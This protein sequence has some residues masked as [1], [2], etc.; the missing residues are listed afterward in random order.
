MVQALA[1]H[2]RDAQIIE[3]WDSMR[4][5]NWILWVSDGAAL[6]RVFVRCLPAGVICVLVSIAA[7]R[8][9][10]PTLAA[11]VGGIGAIA[12]ICTAL[13]VAVAFLEAV[14]VVDFVVSRLRSR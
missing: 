6:R 8:G 4:L 2:E 13:V 14:G 5:E 10:L 1:G 11:I 12:A 9:G 3:E 7:A